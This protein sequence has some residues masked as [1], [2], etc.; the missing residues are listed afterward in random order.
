MKY[1]QFKSYED[2]VALAFYPNRFHHNN[3]STE[4][5]KK[6]ISSMQGST[7]SF[8]SYDLIFYVLVAQAYRAAFASGYNFLLTFVLSVQ[9]CAGSYVWWRLGECVD[10]R[11]SG[12]KTVRPRVIRMHR[13]RLSVYDKLPR[14]VSNPF[15]NDTWRIGEMDRLRISFNSVILFPL[16]LLGMIVSILIGATVATIAT[17]GLPSS[18]S[19][20][21]IEDLY[22]YIDQR[23]V[24][25]P[26][27]GE[28]K[29]KFAYKYVS[30]RANARK[31]SSE[32]INKMEEKGYL[33]ID[34]RGELASP[35]EAPIL[36]SN[37]VSFCDP[38]FMVFAAFP[39]P[40][41]AAEHLKLPGLG[42]VVKA[43]QAVTFDRFS[44]SSRHEVKQELI[45]RAKKGSGWSHILIYPEATCTNGENLITFKAG[46]FNPG[47]PVQMIGVKYSGRF[48]PAWVSAGPSL[49]HMLFRL[50]CEPC[51]KMEVDFGPIYD[52]NLE[53][54]KDALLYSRRVRDQMGTWFNLKVTNHSFDDVK[55]QALA[56]KNHAPAESV[57]IE[58]NA[59][60]EH[61]SMKLDSI[62]RYFEA[63]LK[64]DTDKDGKLSRD[65]FL[66]GMEASGSPQW[67]NVFDMLDEDGDGYIDFRVYLIGMAFANT[68]LSS[69][70]IFERVY[71]IFDVD[72][73][74]YLNLNEFEAILRKACPSNEQSPEIKHIFEH[75]DTNKDGKIA[76]EEFVKYVRE[77][78]KMAESFDSWRRA[79]A[80]SA[81]DPTALITTAKKQTP[82][83]ASDTKR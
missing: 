49:F 12:H 61:F 71:S 64:L 2:T 10:R 54:K 22:A 75:V 34:T 14:P 78:P 28:E 4:K 72:G 73:D 48:N 69:E 15:V 26:S 41:A 31:Y 33:W 17:Y 45:N 59:I 67:S 65:D 51:N 43:I 82:A 25:L 8:D 37:H 58:A 46:A 6:R 79:L 32:T 24:G 76:L 5:T 38:A 11:P 19:L 40:I 3:Q 56:I 16:R 1:G 9:L 29:L 30:E 66:A 35:D 83:K 68:N 55:L 74:G 50:M 20:K 57:V 62:K 39:A 60:R 42:S 80:P 23:G 81:S 63:F 77:N 47:R 52:P 7:T 13:R 53:E 27:S 18:P 70:T 36:V 21:S 44:A